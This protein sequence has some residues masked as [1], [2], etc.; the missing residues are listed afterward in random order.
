MIRFLVLGLGFLWAGFA[1][2]NTS[3]GEVADNLSAPISVLHML[4]EWACYVIGVAF[5]I[6]SVMQYRIHR[7]NPKLTPLFTPIMMLL[8]GLVIVLIPHF[9]MLPA[10]SWSPKASENKAKV[11]P[12]APVQRNDSGGH[13]G[14]DPRYN[15][16]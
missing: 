11:A 9:S 6:G 2:G 4:I 15:R 14:S 7:Q 8:V 10:E 1:F 3:L 13:W 16:Q 5:I 12:T